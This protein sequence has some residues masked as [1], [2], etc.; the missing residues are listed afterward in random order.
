LQQTVD[1]Q[2]IYRDDTNFNIAIHIGVCE[3]H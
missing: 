3:S 2:V 1:L